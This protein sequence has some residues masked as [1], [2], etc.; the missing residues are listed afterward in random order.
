MAQ[1]GEI[2]SGDGSEIGELAD[3]SCSVGVST[4][5]EDA[6]TNPLDIVKSMLSGKSGEVVMR[7]EPMHVLSFAD[8]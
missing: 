1:A 8:R 6:G 7:Q 3:G 2:S 5:L 4:A